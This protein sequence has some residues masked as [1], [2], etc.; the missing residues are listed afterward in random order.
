MWST[1]FLKGRADIRQRWLQ[2]VVLGIV[3]MAGS[4][5]ITLAFA[6]DRSTLRVIEGVHEE[7]N[8]AHVWLYG[9]SAALAQ[10]GVR[11]EVEQAGQVFVTLAGELV[12][13]GE[14]HEASI[15]GASTAA[16]SY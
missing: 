3:L 6:V 7:A 5:A 2:A 16:Q 12:H 8:S 13:K 11:P 4:G 1:W 10:A 15:W 9:D 14:V